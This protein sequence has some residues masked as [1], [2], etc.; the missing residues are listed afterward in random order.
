LST[1]AVGKGTSKSTKGTVALK[2]S[3]PREAPTRAF[4]FAAP[5]NVKEG[6]LQVELQPV[7]KINKGNTAINIYNFFIF[8]TL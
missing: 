6:S 1:E 3:F 8:R 2:P 5:P 7:P 4:L